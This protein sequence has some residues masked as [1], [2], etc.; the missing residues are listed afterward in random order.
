MKTIADLPYAKGFIRLCDI[1]DR[2]GFHERNGGNLSYHL[3]DA[4]IKASK[5]LL[6]GRKPGPWTDVDPKGDVAV[7]TLGGHWFLV[8]GS[9]RFM[10]N[11]PYDPEANIALCELDKDGAH[12]RILWGLREGGRPTSEFSSHLM[13]HE[14]KFAASKGAMRVIYHAHP[15]N[16]IAMTYVVPANDR[17]FT[18]AIWN[19]MTECAVIFPEGLGTIEW[20]VPGGREIAVRSSKLMKKYNNIIWYYH[21]VF[22]A[23]DSFD[24][25]MG[26]METIEK[27]AKIYMTVEASGLKRRGSITSDG[28]RAIGKMYGGDIPER[29]L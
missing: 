20:M 13:N 1:G 25:A 12:Y 16:V 4:E 22:C 9:G 18:R 19:T 7:P 5:A 17:A 10:R 3:T 11:V 14:V 23:A 15:A 21:G 8:T 29:F 2:Q 27:S 28:Y 24:N 26:Q 6:K